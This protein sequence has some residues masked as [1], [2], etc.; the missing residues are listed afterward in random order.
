[1]HAPPNTS[2]KRRTEPVSAAALS[3]TLIVHMPSAFWPS[4]ALSGLL[5]P[6]VP[7]GNALFVVVPVVSHWPSSAGKPP[8]SS[9]TSC[10]RLL[11]LQPT[12]VAGTPG[13]SNA[14]TVVPPG[15]VIFTRMSPT[16][17]WFIPGVVDA[18][19]ALCTPS[20]LKFR[21]LIVPTPL[22]GRV[23]FTPAGT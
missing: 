3:L 14:E 2:E 8:S 19:S 13:R 12:V 23:M 18:G 10:A 11:L 4:N 21:S 9:S 17:E 7:V 1:I 15:E 16:H 20:H 5:G 22:T 6:N